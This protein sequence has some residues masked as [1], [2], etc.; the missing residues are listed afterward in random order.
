MKL[1]DQLDAAHA[2]WTALSRPSRE[3]YGLTV[4]HDG[5]HVLWHGAPD[6]PSWTL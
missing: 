6:G 2:E 1:W 3:T 4:T 5:A